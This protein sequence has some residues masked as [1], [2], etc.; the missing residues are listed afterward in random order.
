[1]T[2]TPGGTPDKTAEP[3]EAG[4]TAAAQH[5]AAQDPI[6]KTVFWFGVGSEKTIVF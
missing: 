4:G 5:D 3:E 6:G 1:M 2:G